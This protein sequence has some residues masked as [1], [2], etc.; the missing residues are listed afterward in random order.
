M[1]YSPK[2]KRRVCEDFSSAADLVE[3]FLEKQPKNASLNLVELWRHWA[4]VIGPELEGLAFPLGHKDNILLVG[5]ED[6]LVLQE[7]S[8]MSTD[9]LERVNAFLEQ[10]FFAQ[11]QLSLLQGRATLDNVVQNQHAQ[12]AE[13]NSA[14][15][16]LPS[17]ISIS[18]PAQ[19]ALGELQIDPNTALGRCYQKYIQRF[20]KKKA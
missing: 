16:C 5:A 17:H 11:I 12:A 6:N 8:F 13:R 9:I 3:R 18:A 4:M 1:M 2:R 20:G 19:G 15:A 10:P 14:A 7:L